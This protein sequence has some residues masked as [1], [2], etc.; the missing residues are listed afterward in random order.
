[1][2]RKITAVL[3]AGLSATILAGT[4]ANGQL[5][6]AA[7]DGGFIKGTGGY[8]TDFFLEDCDFST[9]GRN[10]FFILE[11]GYRLFLTGKNEE[12]VKVELEIKVLH[13]TKKVDGVNTRVLEE[14][15]SE[16][17][18]LVEVSRNYVAF[19][20]QTGSM[21]YYGED[22]DFY[23][24]GKIV[25]HEGEWLAGKNGAKPGLLMP[26]TI[27]LNAKYMQEIAPGVAMDRAKVESMGET[28][29][30]PAGTFN[31]VIKIFETTPL[32]PGISEFKLH[33]PDVGL[34]QDKELKL[35]EYGFGK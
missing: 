19:C 21:V 4:V 34:I 30:T 24:N 1:M 6:G 10:K 33:A 7:G 25:G 8:T 27:L 2:E 3:L 32:E 14:R 17:G 29:K 5:G 9:V 28:A 11:P 18:E 23:E 26:G 22:V 12:G 20:K 31:D 15:E 16:D 35:K 13:Q